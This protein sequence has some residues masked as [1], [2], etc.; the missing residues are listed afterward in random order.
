[1]LLIDECWSATQGGCLALI[2]FKSERF[3]KIILLSS[4]MTF[5]TGLILQHYVNFVLCSRFTII[6][7]WFISFVL[8]Y[9]AC[10]RDFG[11][12]CLVKTNLYCT[13]PKVI[14]CLSLFHTGHT[15]SFFS[16]FIFYV[17]LAKYILSPLLACNHWIICAPNN[18][19][20]PVFITSLM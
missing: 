19:L 10:E 7:L 14:W 16:F 1:M 20:L 15:L 17:Y 3:F 9:C 2:P 8:F 4:H 5:S 12:W 18:T 11:V 13:L 6:W